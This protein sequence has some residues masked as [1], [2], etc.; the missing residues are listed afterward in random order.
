MA[1]IVMLSFV[2]CNQSA[3][4]IP[5]EVQ[6]AFN[7]KFPDATMV[8]WDKESESEWEAE[9]Q[10]A[11]TKYTASFDPTGQWMESE[12]EISSNDIPAA[13]AQTLETEFASYEIEK[14]EVTENAEGKVYE[15]ELKKGKEEIG[16]SI[17]VNGKVLQKEESEDEEGE[18]AEEGEEEEE[19]D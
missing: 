2:A 17:D 11:G 13:V 9:F 5:S 18:E 3:L 1:T 10:L 19:E 14:S 16:I 8:K 4:D 6:D 12:Y 7:K 15:F